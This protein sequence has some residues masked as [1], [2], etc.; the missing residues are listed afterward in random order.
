[1]GKRAPQG[2]PQ[3]PVLAL[4]LPEPQVGV[5]RGDLDIRQ[6]P[7]HALTA[8]VTPSTAPCCTVVRLFHLVTKEGTN[9]TTWPDLRTIAKL[10]VALNTRLWGNEHRKTRH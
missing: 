6:T 4:S 9:G 1:M 5:G 2:P 10:E 3:S 7:S 8:E